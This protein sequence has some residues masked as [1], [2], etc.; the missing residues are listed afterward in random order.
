MKPTSQARHCSCGEPLPQRQGAGRK[1]S[2]CDECLRKAQNARQRRRDAAKRVT[3]LDRAFA[4]NSAMVDLALER[5][6]LGKAAWSSITLLREATLDELVK[7]GRLV[8]AADAAAPSNADGSRRSHIVC[9]DRLVAA[10][11]A[12]VHFTLPPASSPYEDDHVILS[13]TDT[14]HTYFLISGAREVAREA[15]QEAAE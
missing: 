3:K 6:G 5:E 12:F 7:A 15:C 13:V 10:I 8:K 9:D 4:L 11:Y 2:K 1:R 14:T